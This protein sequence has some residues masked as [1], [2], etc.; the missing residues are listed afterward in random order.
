MTKGVILG[1][2]I[3]TAGIQ[4]DP[5]K[6]EVILLLPTPCTQTE[7]HCFLGYVGYYRR[8][9]KNFSRIDVTLYALTRNFEFI[10][11]DKCDIAFT[12]LKKLV[13]TALVLRGPNWEMPFHISTHVSDTSIGIVLG[14][15]EDKNP[16]SIYYINKYLTYVELNYTIT[17][18]EFIVFIYA[19]N[20]FRHYIT[21]Y[22]ISLYT[23]HSAIRYL[24]NKPITNWWVTHWLLLLQEF[25]IT[26]KDVRER[27]TQLQIFCHGFL[28]KMIRWPWI[29]SSQMIFFFP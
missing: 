6:I 10:W 22:Q 14:K 13:S 5:T 21:G 25:D 17:E 3:S 26:I 24:A 1:H 16:Y 23:N 2:Y 11:S 9:I 12:D 28:R 4:V 8:F 18:K 29:I 27:K 20:K 19:I 7:V 15:E